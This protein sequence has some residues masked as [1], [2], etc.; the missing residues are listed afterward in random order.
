MV[1]GPPS[2]A[3]M[4]TLSCGSVSESMFTVFLCLDRD[5]FEVFV[6]TLF[7]QIVLNVQLL[8]TS[9]VHRIYTEIWKK[10]RE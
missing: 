10:K 6:Q 7:E 3:R 1:V 8:L 2:L 4:S 9:Y 5:R